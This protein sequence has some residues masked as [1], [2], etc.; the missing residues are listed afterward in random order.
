MSDQTS[1][2][3]LVVDDDPTIRASVADALSSEAREVLVAASAEEA[4]AVLSSRAPDI[5]LSDVK[6]PGVGGME[7]LQAIKE[8]VPLAD[9]VLMTADDNVPTVVSAM[10]GGAVDFL[11]KP[12]D[13]HE[14]REVIQ[15]LVAGRD[16]SREEDRGSTSRS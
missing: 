6:M 16:K 13:L 10:R 3:I 8:R 4:L 7:L 14:L 1:I 9:V 15:R 11:C 12:L 5:V 2:R